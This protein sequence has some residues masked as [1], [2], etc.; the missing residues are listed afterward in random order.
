MAIHFSTTKEEAVVNGVKAIVYGRSGAGK[1]VLSA[2]AP[3]PLIISAESGLLSL[4]PANLKRVF[5]WETEVEFP[6]AKITSVD[7]LIDV[8]SWAASSK[9]ASGFE[10]LYLDSVTEIAEVVLANAKR[11]VKDPR[12]AYGELIEKMTTTI[13]AFRDLPRFNVIFAAKQETFKDEFSG[14][15]MIGPSMPGQR[16]GPSFPYLVDEVFNL[17]IGKTPEGVQY[18]YLLTQPSAQY[19]A[20]DRSGAL[21]VIEQPDL[22]AIINKIKSC[23]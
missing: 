14:A 5:G 6:V 12:Q 15:V 17:G 1:T 8:Y 18:R 7:D 22:T 16:L 21:E 4:A 11:Q 2:T 19:D 13:K 23:S 10:T 3:T 20:K 9:E